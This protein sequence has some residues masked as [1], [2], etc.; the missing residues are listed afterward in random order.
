M[1][2]STARL[3]PRRVR[4]PAARGSSLDYLGRL[5]APRPGSLGYLGRLLAP[6]AGSPGYLGRLLAPRRRRLR[7][8]PVVDPEPRRGI[9]PDRVFGHLHVTRGRALHPL[10]AGHV[11]ASELLRQ[12]RPLEFE[13]VSPL[14]PR[15]REDRDDRGSRLQLNSRERRGRRRRTIEEGDEHGLARQDVLVD[16]DGDR[17]VAT[18]G[19]QELLRRVPF[20]NRPVAEAAP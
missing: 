1:P 10:V 17:L 5:L 3:I 12:D 2:R 8:P 20:R 13:S 9:L 6:R 14:P 18:H 19:S 4:V 16:Q 11:R 7:F 15:P